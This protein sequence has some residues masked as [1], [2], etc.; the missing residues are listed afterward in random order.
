MQ[1]RQIKIESQTTI[2][3]HEIVK[4]GPRRMERMV[5][6]TRF[7]RRMNRHFRNDWLVLLFAP[8]M[9][10]IC[11][12]RF[13]FFFVCTSINGTTNCLARTSSKWRRPLVLLCVQLSILTLACA[14]THLK[15]KINLSNATIFNQLCL[16]LHYNKQQTKVLLNP[17]LRYHEPVLCSSSF[18][19]CGKPKCIKA[20]C[21]RRRAIHPSLGSWFLLHI[22]QK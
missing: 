2:Q 15:N 14:F 8:D 20:V 18:T 22:Y 3:T 6:V 7:Q 17:Y 4:S 10:A 9:H 16:Q 1:M 5:L 19:I 21:A 12:L 13:A 11:G